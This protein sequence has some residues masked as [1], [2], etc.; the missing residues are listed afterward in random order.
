MASLSRIDVTRNDIEMLPPELG[1][2]ESLKKIDLSLN[3][4]IVSAT[5]AG[6]GGG[7]KRELTRARQK[8]RTKSMRWRVKERQR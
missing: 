1:E 7:R 8:I 6:G 5:Q 2:I 3:P 4:V